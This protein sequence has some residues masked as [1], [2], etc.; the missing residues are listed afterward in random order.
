MK[1][2]GLLNQ[3]I[4]KESD[5]KK[6]TSEH[7]ERFKICPDCNG[8]GWSDPF[9]NCDT[10]HWTGFVRKTYKEYVDSIED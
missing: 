7:P 5:Y 6:E 4:F 8:L 9:A 10:C 1:L 3:T 2:I